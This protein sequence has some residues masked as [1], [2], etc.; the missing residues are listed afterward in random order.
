MAFSPI[1]PV[2]TDGGTYNHHAKNFAWVKIDDTRTLL[3]Y[4]QIQPVRIYARL[5][6][7]N[8]TAAPVFGQAFSVVAP[9]D[10]AN[11]VLRDN[12]TRLYLRA[13]TIDKEHSQVS[14]FFRSSIHNDDPT[15]YGSSPLDG[16][17]S[18]HYV[19]CYVDV[20]A[21]TVVPFGPPLFAFNCNGMSYD[22]RSKFLNNNVG[23]MEAVTREGDSIKRYAG[24]LSAS[25]GDGAV[26]MVNN[27]TY[28]DASIGTG[29][30]GG[31]RVANTPNATSSWSSYVISTTNTGTPG[32]YMYGSFDSPAD[33][34][35]TLNATNNS[36]GTSGKDLHES[37]NVECL[38][39][40]DTFS[41]IATSK[42]V[43]YPLY[44]SGS[45]SV[46]DE[47]ITRDDLL[48]GSDANTQIQQIVRMDKEHAMFVERNDTLGGSAKIW[49]HRFTF[50]DN[51]F[52]IIPNPGNPFTITN[53]P[54]DVPAAS[55]YDGY[56]ANSATNSVSW[57]D[58]IDW[59]TTN[60]VG[61]VIGIVNDGANNPVIGIKLLSV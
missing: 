32:E 21:G 7:F 28:T 8:G 44:T 22:V 3:V 49:I 55:E 37:G 47:T 31:V 34:T 39:A 51:Q 52:N 53:M 17:E 40:M 54:C 23:H 60:N 19:T 9:T 5:V 10:I 58:V 56:R 41:T 50:N 20:E 48:P 18:V 6:T 27:W 36:L 59:D 14:I 16:T 33:T 24:G 61:R 45:G 4:C 25:V 43:V 30:V 42:N 35:P 12:A 46:N 13:A 11:T 29:N 15:Y 26:V 2:P 57:E 1:T 38:V